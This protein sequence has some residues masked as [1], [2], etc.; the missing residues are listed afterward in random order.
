MTHKTTLE[1]IKNIISKA[2]FCNHGDA[3]EQLYWTFVKERFPNCEI[4]WKN[5]IV[6]LTKRIEHNINDPNERMRIREGISDDIGDAIF[7]HH[8]MFVNLIYAYDHLQNFRISSFED[9]YTHLGSACDL[10]EEFLL[11]TH[12]IILECK[13]QRSET[14][15]TLSKND[16]IKLAEE[17]YD[18]NYSKTYDNY[19]KKGKPP[20]LKL[21][22]R[23]NVLDEC[24]ENM[25]SWK[26]YK[27]F[28]Q[29]IREY[30]NVI[31]HNA[32]IGRIITIGNIVLV[33]KKEKIQNYKK[34]S[35]VFAAQQ[36]PKTLNED[37]INMKEQMALDIGNLEILLND[38]WDKP[39]NDL[40]KLFFEDKNEILLNK[41]N[42]DLIKDASD[43]KQKETPLSS[44][45]Y[46]SI[47]KQLP[48]SHSKQT[49]SSISSSTN[50]NKK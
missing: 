34:L 6:S 47:E 45:P 43:E 13:S 38:L 35:N 49:D 10:A 37:F 48:S 5:F 23:K 32:Q 42:I 15:Q 4:F 30:R 29:K 27:R 20:P 17:W 33:P 11:K 50:P 19:L 41:Y 36:N 8:S 40:K 16:F 7:I 1:N 21:P 26:R 28:T 14:L 39:I 46:D 31:I 25:E 24:F 3:Y 18:R 9:F 22:S 2:Y 12:L 44:I